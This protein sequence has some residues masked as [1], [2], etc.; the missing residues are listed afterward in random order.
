MLFAEQVVDGFD[1]VEGCQ[2]HFDKEGN[3]VGHSTVPEARELLRLEGGGTLALL[4]DEARGG[5]DILAEVEIASAVVLGGAHEIDRVEVGGTGEDG[6]LLGVFAVN[7]GGLDNLEALHALRVAGEEGT[8]ARLALVLDH[9][10]DADRTVEEVVEHGCPLA[11]VALCIVLRKLDVE[12][13]LHH[14][15]NLF[16][17]L[18][19]DTL[20]E[21]LQGIEDL[22][23]KL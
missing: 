16:E 3:P 19:G 23:L 8:A 15:L 9:A 2:R 22:L 12:L 18:G 10:A 11:R 4:A 14:F 17:L 13:L 7:L 5:I 1:R 20:V 6:F 21:L